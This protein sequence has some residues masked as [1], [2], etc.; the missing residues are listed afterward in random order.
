MHIAILA[1]SHKSFIA[2]FLSEADSK[3]LP[4]G[5][6]GA[7]FIGVLINDFL[8]MDHTVT[9]ITTT[10][11]MN[12]D[13][14]TKVY[15]H[16]KF[17]W[18]VVPSRPHAL[19][20]NSGK[21]G[22]IVDF[23]AFEKTEIVRVIESIKPDIVH[24]HWSYEFCG[25]AIKSRYPFLVTVHDNPFKVFRYLRNIYRFGRL[26][27][28]EVNLKMVKYASTVSPY[29][30]SF[31]N[32]RCEFV[33]IIPNPSK[34]VIPNDQLQLEVEIKLKSLESPRIIMINNGWDKLKNGKVGLLAFHE[35]Q[36]KIPNARLDLY[37]AGYEYKGLAAKEAIALKLKNIFFHGS[38]SHEQIVKIM[39]E[40]HVLIHPS[41]EESFGVVLI[42]AMSRGVPVIGG[43]KS[44]AVP[45]VIN[46]DNLLVD[47]TVPL[48]LMNK[49][50]ELLTN[51]DLYKKTSLKCYENVSERFSS[52]IV[53]TQYVEY[54]QE[55]I[56]RS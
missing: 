15:T 45:W 5:Y 14:S 41:L 55:I 44:G 38:V 4:D 37:G 31:V 39:G 16:G 54:Y 32:K 30:Y 46:D 27:M 33:R 11:A 13:Y 23:F 2:D 8:K 6:D 40:S 48:D 52:N 19:R 49:L 34:I 17:N 22:R 56:N 50:F 43:L 7:P 10:V 1:P 20:F 9:A 24:A 36:K 29:M 21:L 25:A 3:K 42:E 35:L 28:S 18:V 47:V 51:P 26:I 53:A 12:D